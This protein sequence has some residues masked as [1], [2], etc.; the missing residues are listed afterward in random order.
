MN[1]EWSKNAPPNTKLPFENLF[2]TTKKQQPS[3]SREFLK[4][5]ITGLKLKKLKE[6]LLKNKHLIIKLEEI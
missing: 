2:P 3:V 5:I 4:E 6:I 1:F